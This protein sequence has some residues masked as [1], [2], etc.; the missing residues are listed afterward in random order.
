M[1]FVKSVRRLSGRVIT[2]AK[3]SYRLRGNLSK[4]IRK[5][6]GPKDIKPLKRAR[7][8]KVRAVVTNVNG[9]TGAST[10]ATKLAT[11]T[12]RGL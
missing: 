2:L 7:R 6:I 8:V 5:K 10:G 3:M 12:T 11:V 4:V 9:N 1:I